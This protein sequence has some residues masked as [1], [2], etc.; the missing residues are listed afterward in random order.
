MFTEISLVP[1]IAPDIQ[2]ELKKYLFNE[3]TRECRQ[4]GRL[5]NQGQGRD[6]QAMDSCAGQAKADFIVR[7]C[8]AV[9]GRRLPQD[10][11]A[12]LPGKDTHQRGTLRS[13]TLLAASVTNSNQHTGFSPSLLPPHP[14]SPLS[15]CSTPPQSKTT[16][17]PLLP[18]AFSAGSSSSRAE[19]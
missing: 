4:R 2:K 7:P 13:Q 18:F 10:R 14:F 15:I 6:G 19:A 5:T 3:C 17:S 12:H 8:W 11:E 1:T 16:E 9:D